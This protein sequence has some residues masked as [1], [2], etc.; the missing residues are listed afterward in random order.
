[1]SDFDQETQDF[2]EFVEDLIANASSSNNPHD[3]QFKDTLVYVVLSL[4]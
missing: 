4:P 1:M 2:E 3:L